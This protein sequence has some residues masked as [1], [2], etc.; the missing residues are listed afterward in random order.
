MESLERGRKMIYKWRT[1][2]YPVSAQA[3]GEHIEELDK[4][5][6]EVT[7]Q[8]LVDDARP[9]TALMHPMYEWRDDI[10]AEKYRYNQAKKIM[11]ELVICHV[12]QMNEEPEEP[13]RA[14]VSVNRLK[15]KASYRPTV[16]AL[17]EEATAERVIENAREELRALER[18]YRGIV[19]FAAIV[20]EWLKE[21]S[22]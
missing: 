4:E 13:V 21:V 18:K 8:I 11:S 10:A 7:P 20:R 5:H 3:A 17:T 15:E 16:L 2:E 14:F 9:E 22:E 12:E 6:G 19:N 1:F